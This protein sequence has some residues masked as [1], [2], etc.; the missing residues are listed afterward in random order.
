MNQK[1]FFPVICAAVMMTITS[2][3]TTA[4]S[5]NRNASNTVRAK[6]IS[7]NELTMDL[8]SDAVTHTIDVSTPDGR[9]K[10][11]KL[12]LRQAEDLALTEALMKNNCAALFNPQF[13][14]LKKGKKY[15]ALLFMAF[16]LA[17]S[18][19]KNKLLFN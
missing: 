8:A 7:Y 19:K 13:T 17:I 15:Y 5:T 9:A 3:R 16:L 12:S 2:C 4:G 14:Y 6:N 1:L 11:Y 10:L 18:I